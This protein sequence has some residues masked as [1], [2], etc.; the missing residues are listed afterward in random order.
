MFSV[1][2]SGFD[3]LNYGENTTLRLF[4]ATFLPFLDIVGAHLRRHVDGN[5]HKHVHLEAKGPVDAGDS[6]TAGPKQAD[7]PP[8]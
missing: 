4:F 7:N 6:L 5:M 2:P 8:R 3:D 1:V